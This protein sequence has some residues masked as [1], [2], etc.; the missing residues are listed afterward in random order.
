MYQVIPLT[1]EIIAS[2]SFNYTIR[3]WNVNTYKEE[4]PPLKEDFAVWSL[5]KLKN[6]VEMVSGGYGKS[7]SFWNTTTFKKEHSVKCCDCESLNGLVELANLLCCCEWWRF[8]NN[9]CN[10]H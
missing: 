7:V 10:R 4:V 6:K 8:F 9:R 1:K 5:L 3:V 2:G